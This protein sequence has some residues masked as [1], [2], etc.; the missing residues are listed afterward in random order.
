MTH[1]TL[2][3]ATAN[4]HKLSEIKN[5]LPEFKILGLKDIGVYDDIVEDG[6]TLEENA[7]I[8]AKFLFEKTNSPSLSEDTGLEV[9]ALDGQPGVHTAR[10]AGEERDPIQ[11]MQKLLQMLDEKT[12]RSAQFRTVISL[13]DGSEVLYFEGIVRGKIAETMSGN[14]GFGY[15]PIFIPDG[16]ED[17]FSDLDSS[18]K[19]TISHR[20]RAV[21]K[22]IEYLNK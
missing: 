10:F 6:I 8:K 7:L 20:A 2:V 21:T 15:D 16:Y 9:D 19:N 11:N 22:L 18:I 12:D 14:E 4:E 3:F 13:V 1:R 17:T 5:I